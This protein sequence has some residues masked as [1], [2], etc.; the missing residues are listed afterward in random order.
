M[1]GCQQSIGI[2]IDRWLLS[3]NSE[4]M[5]SLL[6]KSGLISVGD[7]EEAISILPL[8]VDLTHEGVSLEDV[9]SIDEE[10]EGVLLWQL[11]ALSDDEPELV[12]SQVTWG[13]IPSLINKY[14]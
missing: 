11:Y 2:I 12:C 1:L 14:G 6:T 4:T 5:C 10:V 8:V 9:P 7:V 13:Q 3:V